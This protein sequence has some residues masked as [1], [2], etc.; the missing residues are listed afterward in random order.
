M[1]ERVSITDVAK[2][3]NASIATVSNVV[4]KKG[5]VSMETVERIEAVI[6]ELGYIPSM[7][8]RNLKQKQSHLIGVIVPFLH[9]G[10]IQDNPFY[11]NLV[12]GVEAGAKDREFH[13]IL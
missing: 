12:S 11:W 2:K 3:A 5:R 8:A 6:K 9:V 4:N 1:R 7:S 10:T 13:V